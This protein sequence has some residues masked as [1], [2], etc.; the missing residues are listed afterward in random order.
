[1]QSR[2]RPWVRFFGYFRISKTKSSLIAPKTLAT[3]ARF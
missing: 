2:I 1:M 3:F